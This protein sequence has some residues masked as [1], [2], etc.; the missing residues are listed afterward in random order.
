[1]VNVLIGGIILTI[2]IAGLISLVIGIFN[3]KSKI[4]SYLFME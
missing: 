1:M 2:I 3:Y 4:I